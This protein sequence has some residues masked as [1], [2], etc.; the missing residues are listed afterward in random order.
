M[1]GFRCEPDSETNG[2]ELQH[3]VNRYLKGI[4]QRIAEYCEQTSSM[5]GKVE[6]DE[7][8]FDAMRSVKRGRG[9]TG[10]TI[11]FGLFKRNG[12]VYT[13]DVHD[14]AAKTLPTII[15]GHV[16]IDS[17]IHSDGWRGY[18]GLADVS[19]EKHFRVDRG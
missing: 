14:C 5:R 13:E 3:T 11:A 7:S 6:V 10:K 15:R 16:S 4:R 1:L 19:Y 8:F 9:A 2:I 18:D 17:V 12:K